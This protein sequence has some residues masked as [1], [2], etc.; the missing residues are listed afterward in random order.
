M[1]RVNFYVSKL[2]LERVVTPSNDYEVHYCYDCF[3]GVRTEEN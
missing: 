2:S 3:M 1:Y